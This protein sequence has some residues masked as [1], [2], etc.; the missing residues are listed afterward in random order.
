MRVKKPKRL[1]TSQPMDSS[2]L[3]CK[4]R[5]WRQVLCGV[6]Q[7]PGD[8]KILH[9]LRR[10][11]LRRVW[12]ETVSWSLREYLRKEQACQFSKG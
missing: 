6:W 11:V 4:N 5:G 12:D 3:R 10:K 8:R 1:I 7:T 2:K 9:E